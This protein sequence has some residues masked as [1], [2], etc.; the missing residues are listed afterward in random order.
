MKTLFLLVLLLT[1][2]AST[3]CAANESGKLEAAEVFS[4]GGLL[5]ACDA[6]ANGGYLELPTLIEAGV[7]L[8][9]PGKHGCT[10]LLWSWCHGHDN[11]FETLLEMGADPHATLDAEFIV[12]VTGNE[13]TL[14][15]G[16]SVAAIAIRYSMVQPQ[17]VEP[18]VRYLRDAN[19]R[20]ASGKTLLH[21]LMQA[22]DDKPI[23][24]QVRRAEQHNVESLKRLQQEM[25]SY[26]AWKTVQTSPFALLYQAGLQVDARDTA[27]QTA[28]QQYMQWLENSNATPKEIDSAIVMAIMLFQHTDYFDNA[29]S[30]KGL[31]MTWNAL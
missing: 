16:S 29:K 7:D 19:Q 12:D 30:A 27:G 31:F 20:D 17:F 28:F 25:A 9:Q 22:T 26:D 14:P 24:R 11:A 3:V 5:L 8:N 1:H 21:N 10:L 4:S 6:I 18:V 23:V 15:A 13:L 2:A